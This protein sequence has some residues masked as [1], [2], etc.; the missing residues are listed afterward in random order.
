MKEDFKVMAFDPEKVDALLR[1]CAKQIILPYHGTL[2]SHQKSFKNGNPSDIVTVADREAEAFLANGLKALL[3]DSFVVGEEACAAD[4][5]ILSY[6]DDPQKTIWVIDP[7]DGTGNFARGDTTFCVLIALVAEGKTQM[8]WIYD[9]CNDSMAFA[10]RG[11]GAFIDGK[12]VH[13]GSPSPEEGVLRGY[14]G[15]DDRKHDGKTLI[16]SLRCSGLEYFRIA[17]GEAFFS[18]YGRM[19]PWDHLAG[20]LLVQEAGGYARKWNGSEYKPD[21]REG[22]IIT[23]VSP[24]VWQSVRDSIPQKKIDRYTHFD[25]PKK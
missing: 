9:V 3:P 16:A 22:G 13:V 8:G 1:V 23:A 15:V 14:A 20:S 11:K 4:D 12:R 7:V 6:L 21:D 24:A 25:R 19:K 2:E 5:S 17:K 10:Q 18:F